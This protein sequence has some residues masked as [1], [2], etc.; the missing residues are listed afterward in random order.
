[1]SENKDSTIISEQPG[2]SIIPQTVNTDIQNV[3]STIAGPES[4]PAGSENRD[5]SEMVIDHK[6]KIPGHS[7]VQFDNLHK[8]NVDQLTS[9]PIDFIL[10]IPLQF[11][12]E[13]GRTRVRIGDLLTMGP[14]SIIELEKLA[15][16]PLEVFVNDKLVAKGEAV[17][18]NEKFGI[19]LTDV[20]SA[21]ERLENL[22]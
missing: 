2:D 18:I 20:I 13:V 21:K 15:G 6:E 16:E 17:I 22:R 10:D 8:Q 1:M 7:T 3:I 19:R 14:G 5:Q 4:L 12:V 11:S 9:R